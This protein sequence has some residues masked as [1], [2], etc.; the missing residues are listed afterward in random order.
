MKLDAGGEEE[1][2][3]FNLKRAMTS[4]HYG[5]EHHRGLVRPHQLTEYKVTPPRVQV[6]L[7]VKN[8]NE[9]LKFADKRQDAGI[10]HRVW[11]PP[12]FVFFSGS[13]LKEVVA[14]GCRALY[15]GCLLYTSPSP[16]DGLLSRMPSSA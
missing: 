4:S 6:V 16:R 9:L 3:S 13:R 7:G 1:S 8:A 12:F 5:A 15:I 11:V 2:R 10:L 14:R